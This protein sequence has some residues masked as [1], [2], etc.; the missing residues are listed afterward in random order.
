[1]KFYLAGPFFTQEQIQT[2]EQ[3]EA[4]AK[5]QGLNF[6]SPRIECF[7]PPSAPV[8]QRIE[9][10]R[11][12][13]EGILT[14]NFV[15]ARIDDFDPGTI[16]EIGYAYRSEV[17]VYAFTTVPNRGLNL[18]LSQSC[19]GFIREI[20]GVFRFFEDMKTKGYSKEA[21]TWNANII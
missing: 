12:N 15:L 9:S 8:Q 20:P 14:S 18:M 16:W 10:F 6:F 11:M 21:E 7:C 4:Q 19:K 13:C 2:M 5:Y 1:M 3:I 17:P